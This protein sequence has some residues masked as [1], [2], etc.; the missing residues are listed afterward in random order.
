[1]GMSV[2]WA[3]ARIQLTTG[4]GDMMYALCTSNT[5]GRKG[6]TLQGKNDL[7]I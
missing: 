5:H 3:I 4:K 2:Q 7:S 6:S 1:M